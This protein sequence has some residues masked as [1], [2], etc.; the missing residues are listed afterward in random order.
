MRRVIHI[1]MAALTLALAYNTPVRA[2]LEPS[3]YE[4]CRRISNKLA[5]VSLG[6]CTARRLSNTG[7]TSVQGLPIAI[8]EYPPLPARKPKARILLFGGMHGDEY[9]TISILFKWMKTLDRHHSGLFHW[10]VAPLVNPDGLLQKKSQRMN[11]NGVDLNR[12]FPTPNWALETADYWIRRT[13]RNPRRYPGP[14]SLSEPESRWLAEEIERFQPHAI[15]ALHA[16]HG[17]VDFDGPPEG[18]GNLGHL[19]LNVL[20]TYPGSLGNFAGVQKQIPVVTIELKHAGIMPTAPQVTKI[21]VDM[22][23]WLKNNIPREPAST[24]RTADASP[25]PK[26]GLPSR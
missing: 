4:L 18:P 5:S 7:A 13:G 21:W 6:E 15:I 9:S 26:S 1:I 24:V 8:K 17:V 14:K 11:A 20:G 19:Y 23:R 2:E 12:N 22:V 10:R 16:P 3:I 25:T